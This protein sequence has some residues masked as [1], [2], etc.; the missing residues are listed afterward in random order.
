MKKLYI[1]IFVLFSCCTSQNSS[2]NEKPNQG[3]NNIKEEKMIAVNKDERILNDYHKVHTLK[4]KD[5]TIIGEVY[6]KSITEEVFESLL[7]IKENKGEVDTLYLIK[8]NKFFN[9]N[10]IDIET[11]DD[12]C[13]EYKFVLL[14][15]DYII[16]NAICREKSTVSD[17][18]AIKWYDKE[19]I[20]K[21][22][23]TPI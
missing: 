10:G 23:R 7:I 14:K 22:R 20:L 5:K 12:N 4:K 15:D 21:V 6:I 8:K 9:P 16:V 13:Y 18:I 2:T 17:D 3:E 1:L 19:E 11:F